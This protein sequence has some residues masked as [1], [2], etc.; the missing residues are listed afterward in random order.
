MRDPILPRLGAAI[1][2]ARRRRSFGQAELAVRLGRPVPRI[3]E[4]ETGLLRG[5]LG[6]DRLSLLAEVCDALDLVLVAA[7]R[8]AL[9]KVEAALADEPV[10]AV[11][12]NQAT[13]FDEV[14]V[15]LSDEASEPGAPD[16]AGGFR[17]DH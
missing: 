3:S 10:R 12:P 6:R 9:H 17:E 11:P 1:R 13:V 8:E 7:P 4:L 15:D 14:F 16:K 5:R 2:Q